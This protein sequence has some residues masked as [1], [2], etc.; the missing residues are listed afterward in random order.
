MERILE[1]A[2]EPTTAADEPLED[3]TDQIKR[4]IIGHDYEPS[5]KPILP[6]DENADDLKIKFM[7]M[8]EQAALNLKRPVSF[9]T[10]QDYFQRRF[11]R[12]LNIYY[13]TSSRELMIQIKN[14]AD[15]DHVI[16]L[17]EL[18]GSKRRMRLILARRRETDELRSTTTGP[19]HGL[20][21]T[22]QET[23]L[24]ETSSI[25]ST[26]STSYTSTRLNRFSSD[27]DPAGSPRIIKTPNPPSQWRESRC[28]GRGSFGHVYV[29]LNA[30]T[31]EQLVVKKIYLNGA[32]RWNRVLSSLENE[33]TMLSTLSHPHIVQYHGCTK[34]PDCFCIFMEFM[35]G[36]TLKEQ[37]S[38]MGALSEGFTIDFTTQ[39]LSGLSY[40]HGQ[41]IV[42]RDIK[43]A[44]ILRHAKAHVKIGDFGS[45]NYLQ[46]ICSEQGV[47]IHGTPQYQAPEILKNSR[48]FEQRSDIWS[49]A[50]TII[51]M[52][53][54]ETP[55]SNLD[56]AAVH[57]KIAYEEPEYKLP[58]N[59]SDILREIIKTMLQR[60]PEKRPTAK[61]LLD[62]PPFSYVLPKT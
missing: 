18:S 56:P 46:A 7:Y 20:Y 24:S 58:E 40:L 22:I 14:Q 12:H 15:L 2:E 30:D 23:A 36:G 27:D 26:G 29:C 17:H 28:L 37:I 51:E 5:T 42:H 34:L 45:A 61:Q 44:N 32:R 8:E 53:T 16:Q 52:L 11:R 19:S 4:L 33:V 54:T 6:I 48:R 55:W 39:I 31:N 59:T 25:F 49:L 13:T 50:I 3:V 10:L 62:T 9:S 1:Y 60:E 21:H 57:I 47:D 38:E 43:S 41:S 35:T